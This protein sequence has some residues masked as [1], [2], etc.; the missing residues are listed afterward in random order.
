M[1]AVRFT[2][3]DTPSWVDRLS[4]DDWHN[5]ARL[6]N[7]LR[8][9][10][11]AGDAQVNSLASESLRVLRHLPDPTSPAFQARGLVVGYVQSGKTANYTAVAARAADAGYRLVIVLSGIHESLRAQTQRRLN[12]ELTGHEDGGVD[13]GKWGQQWVTLTSPTDDFDKDEDPRQLQGRAP[14]LVVAKKLVPILQ[15]IDTWVSKVQKHLTDTPVLVID[16]EADQAS[17]NIPRKGNPTVSGKT[18]PT[19]QRSAPSRTNALIRKILNRLPKAAYIGYT[20]TPF[21]NILISRDDHHPEYGRD[22]FPRDFVLQLPRPARYTGTEELF[23]PSARDR[24]VIC[25][26]P[27]DDVDLLRKRR[28]RRNDEEV[29]LGPAKLPDSLVDATLAFCL[30]GAVRRARGQAGKPHTMLVHVSALKDDQNRIKTAL[31]AHIA[32]LRSKHS[33]SGGLTAILREV[34]ARISPGIKKA[35]SDS[36]VF[37]EAVQVMNSLEL[38]LM[39]SDTD[40]EFDY[41]NR[42]DRHIIAI[43]GNRLSRGLTLQGL[44]ISY[45]LRTTAACDTLLQ[46]ARWYGYR[47]DY[48]DLIRIWT[49]EGIA[50]WFAELALVEESLRD[51]IIAL[52]RAGKRPSE[53]AIRLR[54]HSELFLTNKSKSANAVESKGSWSGTHPQTVLLPL[55]EPERLRTNHE[56]TVQLLSRAGPGASGH[57]GLIFR[58][59]AAGSIVEFLR[60]YRLHPDVRAFDGG[61]IAE[62]IDQRSAADELTNWSVFLPTNG[63]SEN[64]AELSGH[65]VRLTARRK[66]NDNGIGIL[67]DPRHEGVDLPEGPGAYR[68]GNK[69]DSQAMRGSRPATNGL[70]IIYPLDPVPLGLPKT[71]GPVI[72]IALSLPR[73]SD[74]DANWIVNRSFSSEDE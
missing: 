63:D 6:Q 74:L 70:L 54:A 17:I 5:F 64:T 25:K 22:L 16:D 38:V 33:T 34:W 4:G 61:G 26:V 30:V 28:R 47:I 72:A 13:P 42:P 46:M 51:S 7:F 57:G 65:R 36:E 43:G 29:R 24:D 56:L 52:E 27:A 12:R 49:T 11:G 69:Y 66:I 41:E 45:F 37:R 73:T 10:P 2:A 39:N 48:E 53:M 60:S 23:G 14:C 19:E 59:M 32:Y 71:A 55:H 3:P 21:A 31:E 58:D 8:S 9:Q 50:R 68:Q 20:A 1:T 35:P 18:D 62:W 15:G 67:I 44:T 40:D